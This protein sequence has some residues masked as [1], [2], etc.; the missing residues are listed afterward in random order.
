VRVREA[1]LREPEALPALLLAL[2]PV[3]APRKVEH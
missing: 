2:L 1:L 3:P